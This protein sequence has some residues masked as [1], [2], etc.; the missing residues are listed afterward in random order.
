MNIL[1][2]VLVVIVCY[3]LGCIQSAYIIGRLRKIDIREHGSKNAGASNAFTVMGWKSGV[4]VGLIDIFKCAIPVFILTL[5][6]PDDTLIQVVGGVSVVLGHVF[7]VFLG[8]RGGK[9]TASLVGMAL[10]LHPMLF[11]VAGLAILAGTFIS[12]YIAIGTVFML[13]V[14]L[15]WMIVFDFNLFALVLFSFV[16]LLSLYKHSVNFRRIYNHTETKISEAFGGKKTG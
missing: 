2:Y 6:F 11:V 12:D 15:S 7:P 10:G 3:L 8:F 1:Y 5:I 4:A 13:I 9:G 16:I 14:I